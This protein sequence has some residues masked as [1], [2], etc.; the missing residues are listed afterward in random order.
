VPEGRTGVSSAERS[1]GQVGEEDTVNDKHISWQ[2]RS[3]HSQVIPAFP[4]AI[5]FHSR[6]II[7][8]LARVGRVVEGRQTDINGG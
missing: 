6:V 1:I 8:Q 2:E 3:A 5:S 4:Q 7:L